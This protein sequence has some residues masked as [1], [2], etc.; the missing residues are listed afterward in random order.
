MK[1]LVDRSHDRLWIALHEE[2]VE[3]AADKYLQDLGDLNL[4]AA[5][6]CE[7]AKERDTVY[8]SS[9]TYLHHCKLLN[10]SPVYIL[11]VLHNVW[12]TIDDQ[13]LWQRTIENVDELEAD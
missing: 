13:V 4:I 12:R 1:S 3:L 2:L 11:R 7:G 8:L 9:K 6:I 10:L 5:I